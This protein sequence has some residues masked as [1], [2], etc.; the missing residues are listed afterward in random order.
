MLPLLLLLRSWIEI[1]NVGMAIH[2]FLAKHSLVIHSIMII[3]YN[4]KCLF[5]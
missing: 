2:S 3:T 5:Q 4:A 1:G